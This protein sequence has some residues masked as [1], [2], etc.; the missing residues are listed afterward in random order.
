MSYFD[1]ASLVM[2]PSG[3]KDQKVYSVKPIDGTGDLTFS[4]GS[5]IEATRVASNGYIEKAKVNLLLQ[6]NS[7]DTTWIK[8]DTSV[9]SN[10]A[11]YD[12][13]NNAW[14]L[15]TTALN[16]SLYQNNTTSNIASFSCYA[17][18]G[19]SG[20]VRLRFDNTSSTDAN[21]WV[22]LS[23]GSIGTNSGI[24]SY[25]QSVGSGW[26]RIVLNQNATD[27][28][29]IRIYASDTDGSNSTSGTIYIQD[30]QLN[31][32]LVAQDYQETTTT[33]VITGITNDMPRLDYS[34][35]ASCPS[36][37]MEGERRNL[38]T[39]SEYYGAWT[40]I[41]TATFT[42]NYGAS[43]EG[44]N[45]AY[46]FEATSGTRGGKFVTI[47]VLSGT[48]YT[49]SIYA[50]S[51]SGTQKIRIGA[52]DGCSTPQGAQT[53]DVTTEWQRFSITIASTQT[54]WNLFLD[55]VESGT[56]CTGTYLDADLLI[57]GFQC[58]A[59]SNST[60]YIPNYGLVAGATR[61]A[62]AAYKTGISSLIGQTEGT[63]FVE[64]DYTN[65]GESQTYITISDGTI[66]NRIT[67]SY[68]LTLNCLNAFARVGGSTQALMTSATSPAN[69]IKKIAVAYKLNDYRFYING[70]E[71]AVDSS[72]LV[73]TCS[74]ID[75]GSL[76]ATGNESSVKQA[77]LFPTRLSNSDLAALTA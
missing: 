45:N 36:L 65:T 76:L 15:T 62:D 24:S 25:V 18:A 42:A 5:D 32:G 11:G 31:Y 70:T 1:D 61:T 59:G 63:L 51:L 30:A 75:V 54:S 17:K 52:D 38:V 14:L 9:T 16:G 53:F 37:L 27:L 23:D 6:S 22:N 68:S 33:S 35:G 48:T 47:S 21:I 67:L 10:Q 43:P 77:I 34:G 58:E 60:S 29:N 46:R 41:G 13:T 55:N 56:A 49:L 71:V 40:T 44:V 72:A 74:R 4:R 57:Y 3:Y 20:W 39:Q 50:K 7:F 73:P 12:G 26:Y 66:N 19:T 2:I 69:G 8:S 28:N 64:V